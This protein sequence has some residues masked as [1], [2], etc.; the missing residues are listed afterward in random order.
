[1]LEKDR[2]EYLPFIAFRQRTWGQES[3]VK[4]V[5]KYKWLQTQS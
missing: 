1:M 4:H 2:E 3:N 5:K